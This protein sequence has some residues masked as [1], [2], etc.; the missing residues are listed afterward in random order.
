MSVITCN[1]MAD[2]IATIAGLVREGLVFNANAST[3][4]ITLTGGF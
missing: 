2:F 3:L 1:D 4:E